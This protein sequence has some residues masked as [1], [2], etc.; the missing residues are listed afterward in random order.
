MPPDDPIDPCE[1]EQLCA[2]RKESQEAATAVDAARRKATGPFAKVKRFLAQIA[3]LKA[4]EDKIL[5]EIEA[6]ERK[7]A[8]LKRQHRLKRA[9]SLSLPPEEEESPRERKGL[10]L[11]SV[12]GFIAFFVD[13]PRKKDDLG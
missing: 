4:K 12:L 11:M 3:G 10:S 1:K 9:D 6:L 7:H 5:D 8:D 13:K 2:L